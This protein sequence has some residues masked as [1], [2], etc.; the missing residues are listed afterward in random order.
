[1]AIVSAERPILEVGKY[2]RDR[3]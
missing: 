2:F 3:L 1:M